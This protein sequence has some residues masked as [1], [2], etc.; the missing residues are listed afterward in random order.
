MKDLAGYLKSEGYYEFREIPGHGLCA[1]SDFIFTTGLV[2]GLDHS[3]YRG[4][5]CYQSKEEAEIA[6]KYWDGQ[7]DPPGNWTKYKGV[8]GER[9]NPRNPFF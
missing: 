1:L 9:G 5:W 8:G 6:L 3:G 7:G 2:V 4:R